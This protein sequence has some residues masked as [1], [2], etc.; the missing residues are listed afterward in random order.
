MA[1][2]LAASFPADSAKPSAMST[3]PTEARGLAVA[4]YERGLLVHSPPSHVCLRPFTPRRPP[5]PCAPPPAGAALEAW[6]RQHLPSPPEE[7]A[8]V[9]VAW[10]H[11]NVVR[12]PPHGISA[13]IS[14][15]E[16]C[17]VVRVLSWT[18]ASQPLSEGLPRFRHPCR[19]W[20]VGAH[21]R[22]GALARPGHDPPG[23]GIL[24]GADPVFLF[25]AFLAQRRS[26]AARP[27]CTF[28]YAATRTPNLDLF[29]DHMLR[30][31]AGRGPTDEARKNGTWRRRCAW[32]TAS[33]SS[34][35]R[36]LRGFLPPSLLPSFF[37]S[38]LPLALPRPIPFPVRNLGEVFRDPADMSDAEYAAAG[39]AGVLPPPDVFNE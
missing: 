17:A 22:P 23:P 21:L 11:R 10:L 12:L 15:I 13:M 6:L 5:V 26:S 4:F 3:G 2:Q 36:P 9:H 39:P 30:L 29:R 19:P 28:G 8:G 33:I 24:A 18:T 1:A 14:R 27:C 38:L 37:L 34:S 32:V 35:A 20:A 31:V 7:P 25:P 16:A